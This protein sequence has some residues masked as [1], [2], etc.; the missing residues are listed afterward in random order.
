MT[1]YGCDAWI[2]MLPDHLLAA[3]FAG[4]VLK[5]RMA[6]KQILDC[7]FIVGT[8]EKPL[9]LRLARERAAGLQAEYIA[10]NLAFLQKFTSLIFMVPNSMYEAVRAL[11]I[12]VITVIDDPITL[13]ELRDD[14]EI[15]SRII[16]LRMQRTPLPRD[17]VMVAFMHSLVWYVKTNRVCGVELQT[18]AAQLL[19]ADYSSPPLV[20]AAL[21]V[22]ELQVG[23]ILRVLSRAGAHAP[24]QVLSCARATVYVFARSAPTAM[25]IFSDA[26]NRYRGYQH[27]V[28]IARFAQY[29]RLTNPLP[30]GP[31]PRSAQEIRNNNRCMR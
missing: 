24:I 22:L 21:A 25:K 5:G 8:P 14:D 2:L 10:A 1:Q 9:Y 17:S 30:P 3:V 23:A 28:F 18:L 20:E 11:G 31:R 29:S 16:S 19:A 4:S 15:M 26:L 7:I 13:T 27:S 12:L 6:C